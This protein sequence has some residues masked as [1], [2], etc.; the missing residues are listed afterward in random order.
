MECA[1][2]REH[3]SDLNRG[4]LEAGTAEAVRAH[5]GQCASCAAALQREAEV[6]ALIQ[7]RAPR[8]PAPPALR[9]RI[10]AAMAQDAFGGP[11]WRAL[12]RSHPWTVGSLAGAIAVLLLVWG[13]TLWMARDPVSR[14]AAQAVAEH[15]EYAKEMMNRPIPDP[16][17]LVKELR[18]QV[19][20]SFEPIFRGD[21]Q[22]QLVAGLVSDL[23]GKRAAA[24]VYRDG[25]GRYTTLFLMPEAGTTIPAENRM[26][27]ETF[28]PHHRVT[29]GRHLLLWKQRDLACLLI[30]D[31]DEAEMAAMF[32]KIR[33]A[34]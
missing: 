25:S 2:A 4:H 33:K 6:R 26:P 27:I 14:L 1:E 31:L 8:Y 3:L 7:A 24:F 30:S 22:V 10:Q 13:G 11:G 5:V 20:F 29:S 16:P 18:S 34:A 17:A 15:V 9:S 21:S 28:K 23:L 12:L 19:D 32:L